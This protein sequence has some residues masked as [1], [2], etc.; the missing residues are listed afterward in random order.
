MP[1]A[2]R[3]NTGLGL[4]NEAIDDSIA[5]TSRRGTRNQ[6]LRRVHH[7]RL[8]ACVTQDLNEGKENARQYITRAMLA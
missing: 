7:H 1:L 8:T 5:Q 3:F 6:S 4:L 2:L